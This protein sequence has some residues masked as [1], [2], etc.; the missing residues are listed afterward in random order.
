M[1]WR[2]QDRHLR[3]AAGEVHHLVAIGSAWTWTA[4]DAKTKLVPCWMVGPR[5]AG[6]SK[7]V[8]GQSGI[9]IAKR[10]QLTSDRR[11]QYRETRSRSDRPVALSSQR[12]RSEW[13]IAGVDDLRAPIQ[14]DAR[15][16]PLLVPQCAHWVHIGCAA[17]GSVCSCKSD[18][19]DHTDSGC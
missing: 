6:S 14:L 18:N 3:T 4:L 16:R 2:Q 9:T 19:Q 15:L 5:D 10:V 13:S 12:R 7:D 11:K 17:R 1:P 8:P